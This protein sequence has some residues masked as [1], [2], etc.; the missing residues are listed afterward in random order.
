MISNFLLN[1]YLPVILTSVCNNETI[2][3]SNN[4]VPIYNLYLDEKPDIRWNNIVFEYKDDIKILIK[5]AENSFPF[6]L[7]YLLKYFSKEYFYKF[8]DYMGEYG[9]ELKG[10]SNTTGIKINDIVLYNIF[11]EIFSL[12][13]S[14]IT[15]NS[16]GDVIH[17]RNLDFGLFMNNIIPLLHKLT[18]QV[19][20]IK[21]NRIIYKAHTF[22]GYIGIFSG[23]KP[24][25]FSITINQRFSINSG[26]EGIYHWYKYRD[27]QWN[28]LLV[29]DVLEKNDTYKEAIKIL[30][31]TNLVAPVYFIIA[32]ININE[33]ILITRERHESYYPKSLDNRTKYLIQTNYDHWNN[34]PF[35]DNRV[36][37]SKECLDYYLN[38][39]NYN[40][41]IDDL[42]KILLVKP[43]F[44]KLT[45]F[46]SVMIP[47]KNIFVSYKRKYI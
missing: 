7:S 24:N 33:G 44:N 27:L 3:N 41:Y 28:S 15:K 13:T 29:R 43:I 4:I 12:C 40:L 45:I 31:N 6:V 32:G 20:F 1:L 47:K 2:I 26:I 18:I 42:L 30:Q 39:T 36:D 9:K 11:Y 37:P 19:N 10:I 35:F 5:E 21:N 23:I 34:P 38:K 25:K 17:F 8:P 16:N 46:S 22:A 14:I